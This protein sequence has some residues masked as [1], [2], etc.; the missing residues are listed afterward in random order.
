MC[1]RNATTSNFN[2][3]WVAVLN[4]SMSNSG[5]K[6]FI[7]YNNIMSAQLRYSRNIIA[8]VTSHKK[9]SKQYLN[10]VTYITHNHPKLY[11][12][13]DEKWQLS[14]CSEIKYTLLMIRCKSNTHWYWWITNTSNDIIVSA[15]SDGGKRIE[16]NAPPPPPPSS[17]RAPNFEM[18]CSGRL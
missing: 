6:R 12:R 9:M 2:I 17:P 14:I 16:K 11:F 18:R 10:T 13:Y 3:F 5:W 1:Q 15:T 4:C 8:Q 7:S